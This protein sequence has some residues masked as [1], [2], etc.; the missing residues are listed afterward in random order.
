MA[1]VVVSLLVLGCSPGEEASLTRVDTESTDRGSVLDPADEA[2]EPDPGGSEQPDAAGPHD[3]GEIGDPGTDG[4]ISPADVAVD[5]LDA[6]NPADTPA[7]GSFGT[8]CEGSGDCVSSYCLPSPEGK[9]CSQACDDTCPDGWICRFVPIE[10]A[11]PAKVCIS[12][13]VHLCRPCKYIPS[14]PAYQDP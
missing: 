12:R 8:S 7:A 5:G 14:S 6:S 2:A 4:E 3:P 11:S 13:T 1:W 10:G 9:V